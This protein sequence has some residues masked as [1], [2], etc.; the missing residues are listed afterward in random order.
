MRVKKDHTQACTQE[1]EIGYSVVLA[2][3]KKK[4]KIVSVTL[5]LHWR[6][7]PHAEASP[8]VQSISSFRH[9]PADTGH[10]TLSTPPTL[11]CAPACYLCEA[12]RW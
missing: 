2:T 9:L 5:D 10:S 4:R 7:V 8:A 6:V 1:K 11:V 3:K 12:Q